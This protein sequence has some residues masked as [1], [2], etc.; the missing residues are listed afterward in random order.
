MFFE[1]A[2]V[3]SRELE[4]TLTGKQCG[5]SERVPMCG[6]P[7]HAANIYVDKLVEKGYKVSICEQVEDPK[8][9]KTLVKRDIVQVVSS[10]TVMNTESLD[11]GSNNYI[12]TILDLKYAYAITFGDLTTGELNSFILEHDEEKIVNEIIERNIKEVVIDTDFDRTILDK[13]RK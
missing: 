7:F 11:E 5:L 2:E 6:V 3:A 9:T 8:L 12:G 1:D 10:G 4:L 13:A